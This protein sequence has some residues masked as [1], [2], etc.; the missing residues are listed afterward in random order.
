MEALHLEL[1]KELQ[2]FFKKKFIQCFPQNFSAYIH[3]HTYFSAIH[4]PSKVSE[5]FL[6]SYFGHITW[7]ILI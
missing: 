4:D 6:Q 7:G 2:R 1:K 3:T 5:L